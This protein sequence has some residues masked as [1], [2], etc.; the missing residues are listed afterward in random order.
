MISYD[1]LGVFVFHIL[2]TPWIVCDFFFFLFFRL[3]VI[4]SHSLGLMMRDRRRSVV[5]LF[6]LFIG[7]FCHP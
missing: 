7:F 5:Y 2:C 6:P 3:K 1:Y 4:G